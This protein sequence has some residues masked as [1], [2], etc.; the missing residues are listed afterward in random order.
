MVLGLLGATGLTVLRLWLLGAWPVAIFAGL[1]VGL[2]LAL[3]ALHRRAM[4]QT[5]LV[6]LS[7]AALSIVQI[8]PNGKRK[9]LQLQPGW[10]N[11]VLQERTGRVPAL[12]LTSRGYRRE[13]ARSLGETEKR[14]LATALQTAL[15]ALR[16]P[17]FD[18][19]QLRS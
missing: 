14:D 3:F 6:L 12:L 4:R 10:L 16:N 7:P 11:V 17:R 8:A 13:I 1:E 15:H 19:P 5:E 2:F 18:N 9:T